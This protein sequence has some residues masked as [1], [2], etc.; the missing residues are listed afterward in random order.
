M[1]AVSV[2]ASSLSTG[3][4]RHR[5]LSCLCEEGEEDFSEEG[6]IPAGHAAFHH[7]AVL[8]A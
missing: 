5:T 1:K 6:G 8:S 4:C 7:K 2:A 3:V